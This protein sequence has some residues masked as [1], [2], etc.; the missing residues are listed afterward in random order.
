MARPRKITDEKLLVAA[1]TVIGRLGP[2]FALADVAAEAGVAAGTLV[3]RF[4]SKQG[5]LLAMIDTAIGSLRQ[6]VVQTD[7]PCA[8]LVARFAPLDDPTTAANS[9]AQL[10]FE[11]ADDELRAR[12]A[13]FYEAIRA[14]I[15]PL[16]ARVDLPGAP[17]PPVAAR[18]LV[19]IA[20]GT[21]IDWSASPSGGL[22]E[23]MRTDLDAVIAGWAHR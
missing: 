13:V 17:P 20:N 12:L 16:L 8:E 7:D 21:A 2:R 10:G 22:T 15:E 19:A 5:L 14:R 23:R 1:G 6:D 9:L 11:L 3:H 4:G 18:I